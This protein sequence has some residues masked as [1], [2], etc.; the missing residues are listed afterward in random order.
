MMPRAVPLNRIGDRV[1]TVPEIKKADSEPPVA[2]LAHP[3][4]LQP[5]DGKPAGTLLIH[6]I[7]RSLQGE[8]TFAG[9]PCVFIRLTACNLRCVYC[10]TPHAFV[11]GEVL[12]L[13]RIVAL[14]LELGDELVEITGGEPLLQPEVYPLMTRLADAGK[15]VLLETSGAIDTHTVDARVHIILD[16]K[17]PG[18]GEVQSNVWSNLGQL[19]P[20][21]EVKFVVC[22]RADFD[23]SANV[24]RKYRINDVCPVLM[25]AAFGQVDPTELAG[26]LLD[27]RLPVRL[28][29]QQ[30]KILWGPTARGV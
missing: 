20:I 8:S 13:E 14:A 27:S 17:T 22:D 19:K 28:Q 6:E 3:H 5:L 9:L 11:Q 23:W 2:V 15:T 12:D 29:L 30:H 7:Y 16:V 18:S 26:W 24:I 25:S 21:D 10:D 4:R 1:A